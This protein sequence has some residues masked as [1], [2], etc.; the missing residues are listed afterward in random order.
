MYSCSHIGRKRILLAF[1]L[2]CIGSAIYLTFRQEVLFLSW[3]NED[4]LRYVYIDLSKY[5]DIGLF[6]ELFIYCVPDALWFAALLILQIPYYQNSR[7]SRGLIYISSLLPF[8]LE[9]LQY[10][11]VVPGSFDIKDICMY[12]LTL[13]IVVIC[14]RKLL[15]PKLQ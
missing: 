7:L 15:F 4:I 13:L 3:L 2:L 10:F 11:N 14:E 5:Q 12:M 6:A 1:I 8:L 9:I